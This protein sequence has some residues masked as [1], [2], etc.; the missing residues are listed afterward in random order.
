MPTYFNQDLLHSVA[1]EIKPL[2]L[3]L[4]HHTS[5]PPFTTGYIRALNNQLQDFEIPRGISSI[6][7][8]AGDDGLLKK[9]LMQVAI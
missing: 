8:V 6:L 3:T 5:E 9:R 1:E 2:G 4:S 7:Q